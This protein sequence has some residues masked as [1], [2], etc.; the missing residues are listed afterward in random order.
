MHRG[1]PLWRSKSPASANLKTVLLAYGM[2]RSLL[3]ATVGSLVA[4]SRSAKGKKGG[5]G[6]KEKK[7]QKGYSSLPCLSA[8]DLCFLLVLHHFIQTLLE[9]MVMSHASMM[10]TH[11]REWGSHC[12]ENP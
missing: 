6:E 1:F 12:E 4:T 8:K 3:C 2:S 9:G 5:G 11:L 10:V 7:G